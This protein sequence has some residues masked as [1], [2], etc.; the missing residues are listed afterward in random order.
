MEGL[1][2]SIQARTKLGGMASS[3][4]KALVDKGQIRKIVPPGKVQGMYLKEDVDKLAEAMQKFV[5]V[6]TLS[7][8][9]PAEQPP[10]TT[11]E[12][13][14]PEDMDAVYELSL[15]AIG[16]TMNAE[17]RRGWL[18]VNPE[19]CYIVKHD[20]KVVAF[21]HLLAMKHSYLMD[22]MDGKIRGWEI[23]PDRVEQFKPGHPVECL[24]IIASEQDIEKTT[25]QHYVRVLLRGMKRRLGELGQ[26]GIIIDSVYATS[27][28]P[29]GI[30]M[31]THAGMEQYGKSIGKR[32]TFKMDVKR[33]TSFLL[34]DYK[35][36]INQYIA[37][38]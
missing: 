26:Q 17:T 8:T 14:K 32:L 20:S 9:E 31:A 38:H 3:S 24:A 27:Q 13:A 12:I 18:A 28:T 10:K 25:R 29:T 30:A 5:E 1:Y 7:L 37:E 4:F 15:R 11:F 33:S 2:T 21:F 36:A 6:Y 23:T 34:E 16:N 22:F 35:S 19:S